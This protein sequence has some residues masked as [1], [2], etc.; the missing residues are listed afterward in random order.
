MTAEMHRRSDGSWVIAKLS[1]TPSLEPMNT[2]L[3]EHPE[4]LA[5]FDRYRR[6]FSRGDVDM[7][8]SVWIMNPADR[9]QVSRTVRRGKAISV[10]ISDASLEIDGDRATVAF[11]QEQ[12][13]SATRPAAKSRTSRRGM[14]AFDSAGAWDSVTTR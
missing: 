13:L 6:A 14:A 12:S 7:L 11:L 3:E 2:A 10:R 9:K 8:S 1:E 4:L 5:T